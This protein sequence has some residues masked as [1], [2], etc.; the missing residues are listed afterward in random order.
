METKKTFVVMG[1][2]RGGTTAVTSILIKAGIYMGEKTHGNCEDPDFKTEDITAMGKTIRER[3]DQYE[4]WGWKNPSSYKYIE[5][6]IPFLQRPQLVIVLRDP[7]AMM[8][9]EL[10]RAKVNYGLDHIVARQRELIDSVQRLGTP[11]LW[12]SYEQLLCKTH[13]TVESIRRFISLGDVNEMAEIVGQYSSYG[14]N[15]FEY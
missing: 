2:Y 6:L 11:K 4:Y 9:S 7:V 10:R 8:E 15:K 12:I 14:S 3:N 1:N 5:Q 13:I